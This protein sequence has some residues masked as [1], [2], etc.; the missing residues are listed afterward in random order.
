MILTL[1]FLLI[2]LHFSHIGFTEDL[3]F[4]MNPPFLNKTN[5]FR[6]FNTFSGGLV[7]KCAQ[8]IAL[9]YIIEIQGLQVHFYKSGLSEPSQ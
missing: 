8:K 9:Y 5:K 1:P 7:Q 2:T 3:T 6:S 4:M